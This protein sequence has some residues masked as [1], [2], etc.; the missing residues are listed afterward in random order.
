MEHGRSL[1]KIGHRSFNWVAD[2]ADA[3]LPHLTTPGDPHCPLHASANHLVIIQFLRLL[4]RNLICRGLGTGTPGS[5]RPRSLAAPL[6][7]KEQLVR[8]EPLCRSTPYICA[9]K[10]IF[11][12]SPISGCGQERST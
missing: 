8:P 9:M 7:A 6:H 12:V 1:K 11:F 10:F 5:S 2:P 4:L 3:T